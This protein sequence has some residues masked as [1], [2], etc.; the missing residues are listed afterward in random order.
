MLEGLGM[1]ALEQRMG[2]HGEAIAQDRRR[3]QEAPVHGEREGNQRTQAQARAD[4]ME[5]AG[6]PSSSRPRCSLVPTFVRRLR[7]LML[8]TS[9]FL[10]ASR[11][12]GCS[13]S[14]YPKD[15][16]S[17]ALPCASELDDAAAGGLRQRIG[18][19]YRI[20]LVQQRPDMEFSRM[21]GNAE[22]AG[23]R[24]A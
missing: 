11:Q 22:P 18:P 24:L 16:R 19:P 21:H 10:L 6:C 14:A 12:W 5:G 20:Q 8:N 17:A 15:A 2:E 9:S 23:G 3:R 4:V 13:R 7:R 1:I